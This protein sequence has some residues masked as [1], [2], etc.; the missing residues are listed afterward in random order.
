M[1]TKDKIRNGIKNYDKALSKT[2]NRHSW[3]FLLCKESVTLYFYQRFSQQRY[4]NIFCRLLFK[5][6]T[7]NN[8][9]K[10]TKYLPDSISTTHE[11]LSNLQMKFCEQESFTWISY[12]FATDRGRTN[13][14]W[15]PQSSSDFLITRTEVNP[16]LSPERCLFP[17]TPEDEGGGRD[18]REEVETTNGDWGQIFQTRWD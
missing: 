12:S 18:Q 8:M 15:W 6:R 14:S 1:T 11:F 2:N 4:K 16:K 3:S 17:G 10:E 5:T 9:H 7:L 13:L